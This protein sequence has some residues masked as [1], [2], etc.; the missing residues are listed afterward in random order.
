[1]CISL[2]RNQVIEGLPVSINISP[3]WGSNEQGF[4]WNVP[5]AMGG[6]STNA[7]EVEE[8]VWHRSASSNKRRGGRVS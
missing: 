3:R 4:S 6:L 2:L 1:M 5:D 7:R 8:I